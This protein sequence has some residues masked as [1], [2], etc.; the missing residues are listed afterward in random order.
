VEF[1]SFGGE[2]G[3]GVEG[4]L[5]KDT[6]HQARQGHAGK[7]TEDIV[8]A[9]LAWLLRGAE[10]SAEQRAETFFL[11]I[12]QYGKDVRRH[13]RAEALMSKKHH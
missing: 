13:H 6:I 1:V 12:A 4:S 2:G 7:R 5:R 3:E 10:A 9:N 11:Q 8:K